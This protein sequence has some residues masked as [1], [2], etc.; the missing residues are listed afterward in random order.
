MNYY[1]THFTPSKIRKP[2]RRKV[3]LAVSEYEKNFIKD[4]ISYPSLNFVKKLE[5]NSVDASTTLIIWR[6][7][8]TDKVLNPIRKISNTDDYQIIKKSN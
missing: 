1:L 6:Y 2:L 8:I 4:H 7:R 3:L 5:M